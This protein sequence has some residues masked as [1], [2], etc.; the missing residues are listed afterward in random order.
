MLSYCF[1]YTKNTKSKN[2][3]FAK[4]INGKMRL[5]SNYVALGGKKSIFI[6]EKKAGGLKNLDLLKTEKLA[7]YQ[8][9]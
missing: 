3:R 2:P 8:V 9:T 5:L 4:T 1:K 7:D 6:K